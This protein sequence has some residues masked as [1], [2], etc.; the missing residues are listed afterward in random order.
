MKLPRKEFS[1]HTFGKFAHKILEDFHLAYLNGSKEPYHIVMSKAFKAAVEEYKDKLTP[2]M[3][4][5]GWDIIHEYLKIVSK[6]KN[7]NLPLN[8]I[9]C[10]KTFELPIVGLDGNIVLNGMIDRI[11]LDPDGI[12]HVADYKTTKN[13]KYL[14]D[15]WF[16]LLTY[17]YILLEEDPTITK[18]RAS[19]VLL[20]HNFEHITKEFNVKEI[21]E[22]KNKY[23]DYANK[24]LTEKEYVPNPTFLCNWCEFQDQC[25]AGKT[26][27]RSNNTFGEVGW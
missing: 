19:Y 23:I 13:K 14:K 3:K 12:L 15:D 2:D 26:Q 11:Q 20:R 1:Y 4:K 8:V 21:M 22:V 16:Q 17:A 27:S 5:E 7:N 10:E 24:I 25:P 6:D 18:V 9:A